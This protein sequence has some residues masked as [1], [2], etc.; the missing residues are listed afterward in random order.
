MAQKAK[1]LIIDD[2]PDIVESLKV[3]LEAKGYGVSVAESGAEGLKKAPAERPDLIILDVM[4]EKIDTGFEVSRELRKDAATKSTPIIMITAIKELPD[5]NYKMGATPSTAEMPA[6]YFD[7]APSAADA[8]GKDSL[9]VDFFYEKPIK[10]E[11][12]LEKIESLLAKK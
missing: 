3:V 10:S 12:L 2:D 8:V 1:I 6:G 5:L 7:E 11:L 4:M 9:P